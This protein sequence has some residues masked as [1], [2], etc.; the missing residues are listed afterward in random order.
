M[1]NSTLPA[2]VGSTEELGPLVNRALF[3]DECERLAEWALIGPVQR[4]ALESFAER[5]MVAERER[6]HALLRE[7]LAVR[8]GVAWPLPGYEAT[9]ARR[10][11]L[12]KQIEAELRPNAK[13]SGL[14]RTEK[15]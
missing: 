10:A 15:R 8:N 6:L 1:S 5:L 13:L 2:Q 11:M 14:G 7:A 3:A 4:A 12:W 9:N